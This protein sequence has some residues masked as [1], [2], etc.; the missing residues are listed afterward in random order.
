MAVKTVCSCIAYLW[1]QAE[2]RLNDSERLIIKLQAE[3][4][5]LEGEYTPVIVKPNRFCSASDLAYAYRFRSS[6]VCLS[7]VCLSHSCPTVPCSV[8]CV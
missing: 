3:V 5:R 2:T 4:D 8:R 1:F 7:V 6:V